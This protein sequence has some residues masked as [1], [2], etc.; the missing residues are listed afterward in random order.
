MECH[1]SN[2]QSKSVSKF[3]VLLDILLKLL[4][5]ECVSEEEE[6]KLTTF[7][8]SK[9][10][11]KCRVHLEPIIMHCYS[12]GE[13]ICVKCLTNGHVRHHIESLGVA[14]HK[15]LTPAWERID[16]K[17]DDLKSSAKRR[18]TELKELAK[19]FVDEQSR[20]FA[21]LKGCAEIKPRIDTLAK[22]FASGELDAADNDVLAFERFVDSLQ[23]E[24]QRTRNDFERAKRVSEELL[25]VMEKRCASCA[26]IADAAFEIQTHEDMDEIDLEQPLQINNCI[27]ILKRAK[28]LCN[29]N[30]YDGAFD[31]ILKHFM[32]VVNDSGDSFYRRISH[33]VLECFLK[34]DR[35][36]IE[37]EDQV[38]VVVEK[39]FQFDY[40]LRKKLARQLLSHVRFGDISEEVLQQ[41]KVN[42]L[43]P[44]MR[45]EDCKKLLNDALAGAVESNPRES[46]IKN[47]L[48]FGDNGQILILDSVNDTWEE[49]QGQNNGLL[50]STVKV[51]NKVYVIGGWNNGQNLSTVSI[52]NLNT[53]VWINGPSMREARRL[54]GTCVSSTNVIYVMGGYSKKSSVEMLQCDGNG[55]PIGSWQSLPLMN[56]ARDHFEAACVDDKI[57]AIGGAHNIATVEVFD[58]KVNSW[59]YC[60]PMAVGKHSHTVSTYKG[61]IYVFGYNGFCEKYNPTTDTWTPFAQLINAKGEFRGSAVLNDKIYVIGGSYCSEVDVYDI[62]TNSWSKGPQMPTTVGYTKCIAF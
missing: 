33:S 53:K 37:S 48:C 55:D 17:L 32:K 27:S 39:W 5:F 46:M 35:L 61:E 31:F 47:V 49:W 57:Y 1:L 28:L 10:R 51:K 54:F 50:F 20:D 6:L 4:K 43:H 25:R 26:S 59:R 13:D 34:S 58:P 7:L 11:E 15:Q 36:N 52:Y 2:C 23:K 60:K 44:M 62:K 24:C 41:I 16:V 38:L 19:I 18:I 3:Q 45:N 9:K 42:Q 30:L 21:V 56:T 29:Q 22:M 12:D 8:A 40:G 14:K